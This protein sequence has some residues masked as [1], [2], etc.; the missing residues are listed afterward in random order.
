M[1]RGGANHDRCRLIRNDMKDTSFLTRIGILLIIGLNA[2]GAELPA[3][4]SEIPLASIHATFNQTGLRPGQNGPM[5]NVEQGFARQLVMGFAWAADFDELTKT[6]FL[7]VPTDDGVP[8]FAQPANGKTQ[9][10]AG[11]YFGSTGSSP[12][13]FVID[14]VKVLPGA[15]EVRYHKAPPGIMTRDLR[16]YAAWLPLGKLAAGGYT[17]RMVEAGVLKTE[18]KWSITE[19]LPRAAGSANSGFEITARKPQDK[20]ETRMEDGT[21]W[22]AVLSPSGIGGATI[23]RSQGRWPTNVV[24]RLRYDEQRSFERLEGFS[25][26][27]EKGTRFDEIRG[28]ATAQGMEVTL[29]SALLQSNP[30]SIELSWVDMYR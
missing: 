15:F 10:W 28:R 24:V 13:Q 23:K 17:L 8:E 30:A 1:H 20:V 14:A 25:A 16:P 22:L 21:A 5:A 4:P 3:T 26:A 6:K 11:V 7:A 27:A 29:P 12:P 9:L 18:L 2:A 19:T